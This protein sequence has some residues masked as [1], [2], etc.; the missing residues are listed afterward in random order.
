MKHGITFDEYNDFINHLM[1]AEM[2]E[3][4]W[5]LDRSTVDS[6]TIL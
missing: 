4:L 6:L 5:I 3:G 2:S 1:L